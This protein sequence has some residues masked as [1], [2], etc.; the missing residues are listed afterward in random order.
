MLVQ[1]QLDR[2]GALPRLMTSL[3]RRPKA[4]ALELLRNIWGGT[5]FETTVR[6]AENRA[7]LGQLFEDPTYRSYRYDLMPSETHS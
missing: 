1:R 6:L 4:P 7:L 5:C 2:R 3:A